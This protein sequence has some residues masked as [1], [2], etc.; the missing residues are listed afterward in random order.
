[1]SL[2]EDE[3]RKAQQFR[4]QMNAREQAE[5][6]ALDYENKARA[7]QEAQSQQ[8]QGGLGG[9]LAGIG[10]SIGN[11]G[12]GLAGIFGG[13]FA[14]IGD[15][16]TSIATGKATNKNKEDFDKWLAGTDNLKDARLKNA[17][18]ALDAAVTL[19]DLIPV[20]GQMGKVATAGKAAGKA[21]LADKAVKLAQTPI[22]NMA[23]G[24]ASEYAQEFIDNGE[25]ANLE[26]ALKRAAVGTVA[27][28]TGTFVGNKLANRALTNPATSRLGKMLQSNVGRSAITGAT[29]GAVGGGMA[30]A[31]EGGD[32]GQVLSSAAQGGYNGALG[33]ATMAGVMGLAGTGID[34]LNQK[35]AGAPTAQNIPEAPVR[36]RVIETETTPT[37]KGIA[38][39]DYDAGEQRV[40]VRR[41]N[42]PTN[43][44]SLGKNVGSTLDGVLGPDNPR[45][46]P[47]A[48]RPTDAELFSKQTGGKFDNAADFLREYPQELENI[49]NTYPEVY[50]A[51]RKGARDYSDLNA[52]QFDGT[53]AENKSGLPELNR[54]QYYEDTIGKLHATD[55]FGGKTSTSYAD[56]PDYMRNHLLN[57]TTGQLNGRTLQNDDILREFFRGQYGDRVDSMDLGELY[58]AYERLAQ[59]ANQNEIYT[60][61][62]I[63]NGIRMNDIND[64]VTGAF[65][66]DLGLR[67]NID[68]NQYPSLRK[69]LEVGIETP[70]NAE[71]VYT[72]RTIAPKTPAQPEQNLPAVR[73]QVAPAVQE[74]VP[75]IQRGTPE[76]KAIQEQEYI[77]N[78]QRELR[79]IVT[80]GVRSQYGT[81]RLNDRINGLD[82]AIMEL[83]G[84]GLTKRSE[85]DGFAKRITGADGAMSKAIRKAMNDSGKTS[86]RIDITMDDVYR[87]SGASGNKSAM[88]KINSKFNS[89]GKKYTVD[90]DGNM[91]RSDMYDF[92]RE[93]E[94]EG[95]RMIE[96]GGRT[97][98]ADT[99]V[100][101]EAMRM[102]G[103]NYIAKATDG[104]DMSKYIDANK[105]K[106]LLPGNEAWAAHVDESIP[107]IKTVSDARS[108]MAA[109]TKLSLLADAAEYNKGTYGS[110]VGNLAKDGTQAIRAITSGNPARAAVQY[111]TAKA[112]NSNVVKDRVI[113]NA[114]KKY[115]NIEAG[116]TGKTGAI[117]TV[118]NVAG[119]IGDKIGNAASALNNTTITDRFPIVND[120]ATRQIARQAGKAAVNDTN[121]A[122]E[123]A[124]AQ[125]ALTEAQNAYNMAVGNYQNVVA[126]GQQ[127]EQQMSQGAQQLQR[128]SSAM[129]A[130]LAAGDIKAYGQL[131]DLYQQAY[132]IYGADLEATQSNGLGSLTNSQLENINKLDTA[133]NAI[134]ELEALFQKAGGG[135]GLIGGNATNFMASLGL[136]PDA[137]TYN[138][139]SRGLIN[140]IGAAIGKTDS[141]NTEGEVQR[142]ME[143]I[144][145]FTDDAQTA[146]NKL[147]QLRQML[148]TNKQTVYQ[149]YGVKQQQ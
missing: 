125:N 79:D 113:K 147:A 102:L 36:Q 9:V 128:I 109:P 90:A 82:D 43:E 42:A 99:E 89:I 29:A 6:A 84:Y 140:Q 57:D 134:D 20:V 130:A 83:A 106:N 16:A 5:Q 51:V 121:I 7:A 107:N 100:Y 33:G 11:V 112:V 73:G 1:M 118:K 60:P 110:N 111:G 26:D 30:S 65:V 37:R 68:V 129:D 105:L 53:G 63:A 45:K 78:R 70:D 44:Y 116:G 142:A 132:K 55:A 52:L 54:Q 35:V 85:I 39:T 143:L 21:T 103:E 119:A 10:N 139:L 3:L 75:L 8:S 101:G 141:L 149:N 2:F 114:L 66:N 108:F 98:N 17:G 31:L 71:T 24:G 77:A 133:G 34:K 115:N 80:D 124:N 12:K 25:N 67:Q 59:A 58:D 104:V 148:Q 93:L 50:E 18:T 69:P 91:N 136:N 126:Q 74:D 95:Y 127:L 4:A 47:N 32:I 13:G 87:A 56:V 81:I 48:K 62:N 27:S 38:I 49:K 61:E 92:G 40:N 64:D 46:L 76:Y 72:K 145:A 94:R 122:N 23:Q 41:P 117:N 146:S 86:G 22:F 97:Q 14:N 96:R 131:A 120:L 15:I 88:D 123:K 28:G 137:S 138:A 144:P 19:S 135:Q